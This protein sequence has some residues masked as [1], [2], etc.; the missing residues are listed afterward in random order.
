M[1]PTPRPLETLRGDTQE[2]HMNLLYPYGT[3]NLW[4]LSDDTYR[5]LAIDELVQMIAVTNE[6]QELVSKVFRTLPTDEKTCLY[7]QEIVRDLI[8]SEDFCQELNVVLKKL[9][10]LKEYNI[11]NHFL[12]SK[13]ASMW[14]LI[15]YMNEMDIYVQVVEE[16][17]ILFGKYSMSSEGLIEIEK[18]LKDVIDMDQISELKEIVESLKAEISTLKSVTVGINLTQDLYPA[19][20]RV[21][22]YSTLPVV[23]KYDKVAWGISIASMRQVKYRE[24]TPFMKYICEDMEKHL[25]RSVQSYKTELKKYIN[26]KGYF[27]LDICND[28]KFYLMVARLGRT[29]SESGHTICFPK[30]ADDKTEVKIKG[31]YNIR[32]TTKKLETIVRNDFD[33]EKREKIFILTGPNRGGKTM[34]TQAV[35]IA[36]FM[37]G[38][39]LFVTADDYEGFL[40]DKI[41]THFPADENET[42]DL[43]RLGEEAVRIKTIAGEADNKSLVLLNETYSSTSAIDGLYLAK[44]LVH[45]L[46]HKSIPTIYNTHLHELGRTTGEMNRWD[47]E[48]EVVSLVMEI[49]DNVNTYRVLRKEPDTSSYARNIAFKYG[50][51]YEQM[52]EQ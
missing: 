5:N 47:G 25:K 7:R 22:D 50:V 46:K 3:D 10:V 48:G 27:L 38:Q 20:I 17:N 41:L 35:G 34:L 49:A 18:L 29:L 9:D 51:T 14:D 31:I 4:N 26:F 13:R 8:A 37:A 44:D 42:L 52:L 24:P 32:L 28:L 23:S 45:L 40:F 30:V 15:D 33:F 1:S 43:G 39:G 11:H 19:E 2:K 21:L 6:E 12:T 36:A 16:L